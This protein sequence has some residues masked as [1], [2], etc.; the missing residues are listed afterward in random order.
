MKVSLVGLSTKI[1]E[2]S[3]SMLVWSKMQSRKFCGKDGLAGQKANK[4]RTS[5]PGVLSVCLLV[6]C[7][8][9]FPI[10]LSQAK[11]QAI[12]ACYEASEHESASLKR[13]KA[14]AIRRLVR[15]KDEIIK[16]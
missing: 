6:W 7:Y 14:W 5:S 12:S 13:W 3:N 8:C 11:L 10:E 4:R 15:R 2:Q 16:D 1:D 9:S